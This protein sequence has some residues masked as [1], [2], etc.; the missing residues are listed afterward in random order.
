MDVEERAVLVLTNNIPV[1]AVQVWN[2]S[3]CRRGSHTNV[4]IVLDEGTILRDFRA[5]RS[6]GKA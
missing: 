5:R 3:L 1:P 6:E 4:I 2:S